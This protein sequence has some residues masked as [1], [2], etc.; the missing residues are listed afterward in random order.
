MLIREPREGM[1]V[2]VTLKL[3]SA[4]GTIFVEGKTTLIV[5]TVVVA[6]GILAGGILIVVLP[7]PVLI[8]FGLLSSLIAET[9][10]G[11]VLFAV[12]LTS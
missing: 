6:G 4:T 1:S 8:S 9:K 5:D 7:L 2:V 12:P 10:L 3:T 11:R